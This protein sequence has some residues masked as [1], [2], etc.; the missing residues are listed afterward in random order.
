[1][2][3]PSNL[4]LNLIGTAALDHAVRRIAM[5]KAMT[6]R[7]GPVSGELTSDQ[8]WGRGMLPYGLLLGGYDDGGG[9]VVAA[10]QFGDCV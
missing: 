2:A 9:A 7:Y 4:Q 10:A 3:V 8:L 5:I 1:M 6:F